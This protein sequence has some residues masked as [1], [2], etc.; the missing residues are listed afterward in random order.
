M[1]Q[2]SN[3]ASE[4]APFGELD[5]GSQRSLNNRSANQDVSWSRQSLSRPVVGRHARSSDKSGVLGSSLPT[6][7]SVISSDGL[8]RANDVHKTSEDQTASRVISASYQ[9]LENA[10]S[11]A[12]PNR[13]RRVSSP[14][15]TYV[16]KQNDELAAGKPAAERQALLESSNG[17]ES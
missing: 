15:Q 6:T 12:E 4:P 14:A 11:R 5:V 10:V 16:P 8:C 3:A 7:S 13:C 9:K 17:S 2:L 1:K